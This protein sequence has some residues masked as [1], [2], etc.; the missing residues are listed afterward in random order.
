MI[1]ETTLETCDLGGC[2][3]ALLFDEH[4]RSTPGRVRPFVWA[5]LLLRGA[6]TRR[7]CEQ[8][9]TGHVHGADIRVMDDPLERT[10]LQVV[11]DDVLATMVSSG[12]LRVNGDLYVLKSEALG[13]TISTACQLDAQLPD[14]L[15]LESRG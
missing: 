7:E 11:I 2:V 5:Y 1:D 13:K 12:L 3:G 10:E 8:A 4:P 15:L 9:L 14:H 6:V